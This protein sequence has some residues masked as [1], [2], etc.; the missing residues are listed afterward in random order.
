MKLLFLTQYYPPEVGAPQNRLSDLANRLKKNGIEVTVLTAM[1][2]YPQMKVH[3]GYRGRFY[4]KEIIDGITVHRSWIFVSN[5]KS[6]FFRLLNYFS[7]VKSSFIIGLIKLK[8][9][10]YIFC[11][12]PPLF[13]GVTAFL[14]SKVKRSR[15]IFNVSDLWPESAEQLGL[16]N[17]RLMLSISYK[18]EAF[19]YRKSYFIIG[20]T[21]GIVENISKRFLKKRVYWLPNGVDLSYFQPSDDK[22]WRQKNNFSENDFIL[23][24]A[25]II[26]HAQGLEVILNAAYMLLE[27]HQIK[28]ALL[29]NGHEKEKLLLLKK[30]QQLQNVFFFDTINKPE[31][32]CILSSV[33][34]A[35]VPLRKLQLFRG[36]VP[37]KIFEA[38]AMKKPVLLGVDGEAR[39]LFVEQGKC[40]LYFE[41]ENAD[42]LSKQIV[43]LMNDKS[44]EQQLGIN[45]LQY[46]T[47]KFDRSKIAASFYNIIINNMS[48]KP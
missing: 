7:F 10:D 42:E 35:I 29:G 45:G 25:G 28:F 46:V 19:L 6:I 11:E 9:Q 33:N 31:M 16:V 40:A 3:D 4:K 41:P 43:R 20:Q 48:R 36:A 30:N 24:Y 17:N 23:L 21:Q 39:K 26:G 27:H 2:N 15:L 1:P 13:L 34:A 38:L 44:L 22:S 47:E 8:R 18:L 37:S 5:R 14:L 32:P 12:S